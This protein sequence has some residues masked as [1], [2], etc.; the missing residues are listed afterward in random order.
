MT[1]LIDIP[2]IRRL[3]CERAVARA[4]IV[5]TKSTAEKILPLASAQTRYCYLACISG[6]RS[7][8]RIS[9]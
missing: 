9:I 6:G 1:S 8:F 3:C 4:N 5:K 7:N 2:Q